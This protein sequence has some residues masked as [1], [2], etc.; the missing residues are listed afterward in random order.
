MLWKLLLRWKIPFPVVVISCM[1]FLKGDQ[2]A[3]LLTWGRWIG[4]PECLCLKRWQMTKPSNGLCFHLLIWHR[5]PYSVPS[6]SA[7]PERHEGIYKPTIYLRIQSDFRLFRD[8]VLENV[9]QKFWYLR[10][11]PPNRPRN[12]SQQRS[13]LTVQAL[14]YL[15][16]QM[17][18]L[19]WILPDKQLHWEKTVMWEQVFIPVSL[20]LISKQIF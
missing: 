4:N 1:V 10:V 19:V 17:V 11:C 7:D 2:L 3:G 8:D 18:A 9:L 5:D 14:A 6:S 15:G 20:N 12:R 16:H 13:L